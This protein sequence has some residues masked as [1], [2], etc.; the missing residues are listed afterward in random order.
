[1]VTRK[2][3]RRVIWHASFLVGMWAVFIGCASYTDSTKEIRSLY[4]AGQYQS[5]YE[6]LESSELKES[7]RN[8]L[9][10]LLE[11][12]M[13]YDRLTKRGDSRKVLFEADQLADRLYTTSISNE[14]LTYLYNESAQDYPGEDYEKVAIHTVLALSFL[15]DDDLKSATIEARK[16][17][18][19]LAEINSRYDEGKNR[20]SEDALAR[21][22]SGTIY[23]SQSAWDDAII[24]YRKALELYEGVYSKEFATSVPDHLVESLYR[25]LLNRGRAE[26]AQQLEK[27]YPTLTRK[28]KNNLQQI[29]SQGE[30]VVLHEV[31]TIAYKVAKDFVLPFGRQ[32]VRISFPSISPKIY[33]EGALTGVEVIGANRFESAQLLQNMDQIA[34]KTLD[35]RRTRL[36]LKQGARLIAKG[37]LT[38]QAYKN[39]GP[40]GGIAANVYG[41]VTETADT[42]GWTLLPGAFYMT[43]VRIAPGQHKVMIKSGGKTSKV[44]PVT[45]A[46]GGI[47]ILRHSGV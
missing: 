20:Y 9:L 40:I 45:I 23:E 24:D 31:G 16:I 11:K 4:R 34:S 2:I 38:E 8:R 28:I 27:K 7:N 44:V 5:A 37:Q 12:G 22:V 47:K 25:L 32:I 33:G 13:L 18:T 19:K 41:A 42:R 35:D 21:Y 30:L 43:R 29:N 39:F 14:A 3:A 46:G 36:I 10:Y 1:M 17:N 6:K 15:A 26:Q